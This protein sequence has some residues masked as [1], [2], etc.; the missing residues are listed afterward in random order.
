MPRMNEVQNAHRCAREHNEQNA[1]GPITFS[2]YDWLVK[3][4]L[5]KVANHVLR[6]ERPHVVILIARP[7]F[8]KYLYEK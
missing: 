2:C 1:R 7:F 3:V 4:L 8:I 6:Q 5:A